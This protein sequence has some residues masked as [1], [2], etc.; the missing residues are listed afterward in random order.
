MKTYII[1]A[2]DSGPVKIG[3]TR[4]MAYR[5][6]TLQTG[7]YEELRLVRLI[8]GDAEAVLHHRFAA[9]RIRGEWFRF[10]PE[11]LTCD[12]ETLPSP[13]TPDENALLAQYK[14]ALADVVA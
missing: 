5:L 7:H 3:R 13:Y 9:L 12:V 2:G 4:Q 6:F 11:M 10:D 8:D 1:R 14:A